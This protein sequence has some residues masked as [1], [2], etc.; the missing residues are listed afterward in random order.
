MLYQY[1]SILQRAR[2]KQ[3]VEAEKTQCSYW[4]PSK[5]WCFLV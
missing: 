3:T 4:I 5:T 1:I 2:N